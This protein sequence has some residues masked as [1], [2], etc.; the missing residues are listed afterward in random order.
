MPIDFDPSSPSRA[1]VLAPLAVALADR[2]SSTGTS[3]GAASLAAQNRPSSCGRDRVPM[4]ASATIR[5]HAC[6][7]CADTGARPFRTMELGDGS[8]PNR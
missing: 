7:E 2:R 6:V 8:S 1:L 3:G 4:R 5:V